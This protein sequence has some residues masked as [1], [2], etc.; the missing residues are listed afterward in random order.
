M[1]ETLRTANKEA[2]EGNMSVKESCRHICNKFVN[3]VE[4]GLQE[5]VYLLNSQ[6]LYNS[7]NKVVFINTSENP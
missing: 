5:I 3:G 4:V 7:S 2:A 6:K 1:S